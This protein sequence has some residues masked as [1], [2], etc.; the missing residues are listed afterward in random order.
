MLYII[1]GIILAVL[2]L[3]IYCALKLASKSDD[4]SDKKH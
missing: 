4:T 2:V 1:L 3:F